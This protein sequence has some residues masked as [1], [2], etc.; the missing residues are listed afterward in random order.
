MDVNYINNYVNPNDGMSQMI[1]RKTKDKQ[2]RQ[3]PMREKEK[4]EENLISKKNCKIVKYKRKPNN[5]Y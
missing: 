4:T 1:E 3:D 5:L 2:G